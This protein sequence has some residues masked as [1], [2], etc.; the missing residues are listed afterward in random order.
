MIILQFHLQPQFNMNY[1]I[2]TL[3]HDIYYRLE[4]ELLTKGDRKIV[5]LG[6]RDKAV[7]FAEIIANIGIRTLNLQHDEWDIR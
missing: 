3:H 1:F 4:L 7:K 5:D 6:F 2:Y